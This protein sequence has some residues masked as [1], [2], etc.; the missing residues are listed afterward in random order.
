MYK[1]VMFTAVAYKPWKA[2]DHTGFSTCDK[3]KVWT[4]TFLL[5]ESI[6]MAT[7]DR[8]AIKIIH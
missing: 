4:Y 5:D 7:N 2:F 3:G 1:L 8:M 6:E